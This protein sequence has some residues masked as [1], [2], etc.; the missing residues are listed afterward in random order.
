MSIATVQRDSPAEKNAI[1]GRSGERGRRAA[2]RG[3][4]R[5]WK[6]RKHPGL[7]QGEEE[8]KLVQSS[9]RAQGMGWGE[10]AH[11]ESQGLLIHGFCIPTLSELKWKRSSI[12]HGAGSFPLFT[13]G[14]D[15]AT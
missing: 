14:Q 5:G 9:D 15:L 1:W 7:S 12:S 2:R 3:T 6:A 8:N 13:S 10:R 4:N 11:P